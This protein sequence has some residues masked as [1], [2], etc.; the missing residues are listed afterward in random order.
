MS[1]GLLTTPFAVVTGLGL[2]SSSYF[3]FGNLGMVTCGVIKM[4]TSARDRQR[5][6]INPD[7]AVA[8]WADMF[9]AGLRNFAPTSIVTVLTH[10]TAGLMVKK[11][12]LSSNKELSSQLFLASSLISL[13]ILPYTAGVMMANIKNLLATRDRILAARAHGEVTVLQESEGDDV[14]QRIQA[15]KVQNLGRMAIGLTSWTLGNAA[16]ALLLV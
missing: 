6:D 4:T 11:Y 10:L 9:E 8:L 15:W 1:R 16:I 13:T 2:V 7:R 14:L 3:F 12:S 5:L